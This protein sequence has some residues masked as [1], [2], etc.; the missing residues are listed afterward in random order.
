MGNIGRKHGRDHGADL[1]DRPKRTPYITPPKLF[2]FARLDALIAECDE[3][4]HPSR[5]GT[6][7]RA[8]RKAQKKMSKKRPESRLPG[9]RSGQR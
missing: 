9:F 2:D 6:E 4:E 3:A 8:G 1:V 7:M 5:R